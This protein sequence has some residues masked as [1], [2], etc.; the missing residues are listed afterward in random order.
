MCWEFSSSFEAENSVTGKVRRDDLN[1]LMKSTNFI[2]NVYAFNIKI[3]HLQELFKIR[4]K[5]NA[6]LNI[7]V[8]YLFAK[9]R[10][11]ISF[12]IKAAAICL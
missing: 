6:R 7:E 5:D 3:F 9:R 8:I 1:E 10:N 11:N 12:G 4:T 2:E